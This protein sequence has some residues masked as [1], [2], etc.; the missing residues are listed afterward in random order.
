MTLKVA[1][2]T[3]F[4]ASR[5]VVLTKAI[6]TC[7]PMLHGWGLGRVPVVHSRQLAMLMSYLGPYWATSIHKLIYRSVPTGLIYCNC[8]DWFNVTGFVVFMNAAARIV[9][10]YLL[11]C[12]ALYSRLG[13][14]Y[15]A[16]WDHEVLLPFKNCKFFIELGLNLQKSLVLKKFIFLFKK[17]YR[18]IIDCPKI[19]S[20]V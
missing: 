1:I 9:V 7:I 20:L 12:Q 2:D 14:P 15:L 6:Q 16:K 5:H 11:V 8:R 19:C 3:Q 17:I 13:S 18:L 4:H 10:R